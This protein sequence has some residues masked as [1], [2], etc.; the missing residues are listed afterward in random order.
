MLLQAIQVAKPAD[1]SIQELQKVLRAIRARPY[2]GALGTL[3]WDRNGDLATPPYVIYVAKR[4]GSV[5]GWF[6]QLV[7]RSA[8]AGKT[9]QRR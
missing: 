3:R 6:E 1:N 7:S 5:Q 2:A 9:Q 8:A 4:R